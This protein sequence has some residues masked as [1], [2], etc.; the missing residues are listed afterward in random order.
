LL[1]SAAAF[2]LRDVGEIMQNQ[3]VIVPSVDA[4]NESMAK[5]H[6][7]GVFS[8][9]ANASRRFSQVRIFWQWNPIDYEYPDAGAIL[10]A[11]EIRIASM[12]R[13]QWITTRE[14]EVFLSFGPVTS[15]RQ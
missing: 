9:D 12:S 1:K 14:N 10:H 11:H 13:S 8:D 4:N 5:T 3:F 6:A 7:T 2:A 15:E